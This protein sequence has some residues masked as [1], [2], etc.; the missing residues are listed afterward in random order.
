[1]IVATTRPTEMQR[2]IETADHSAAALSATVGGVI[3]NE[4]A[5]ARVESALSEPFRA[6]P[7]E[8]G[9]RL[10]QAAE[11]VLEDVAFGRNQQGLDVGQPLLA[12]LDPHLAGLG[13]DE[14]TASDVAN[15]CLYLV[16]AHVQKRDIG[17]ARQ[18]VQVCLRLVPDLRADERLHPPSVRDLVSEARASLERGEGGILAVHAAPTDPE[19]CAIRV[20]GRRMGQTPWARV[21]LPPGPYVVQ[22]ECAADRAGRVHPVQVAGD[23]P[24]RV[25]IHVELAQRLTT[26]PALA[27][28]YTSREQLANHLPEDVALIAHTLGATRMLAAVDD[29][30]N[31][32]VRAFAVSDEGPLLVGSA[33]VPEPID[34]TRSREAVAAVLSGRQLDAPVESAVPSDAREEETAHVQAG[35]GGAPNVAS[36]VLGSILALG[37]AAGL[38]VGWYYWTELEAAWATFDTFEN[39]EMTVAYAQAQDDIFMTRWIVLGTGIGGGALLTM[40]LPFLLP[41]EE[42]V[43]WWSFIPAAAGAALAGVGIWQLTEDGEAIGPPQT[44]T[45]EPAWL[46]AHLIAHAVPLLSVPFIYLVRDATRDRSAGAAVHVDDQRAELRV[47]GSF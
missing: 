28:V 24:T 46:G 15:L 39:V 26:R 2:A 40:A 32:A 37:G 30:R 16:R 9:R 33:P 36:L 31:L 23:S 1:M 29:G 43:P 6:A 25:M 10:G 41:H 42:G 11:A 47:W 3:P 5:V 8:I 20:N 22:I 17:A 21:P 38:C 35:G 18:Q 13:R 19:G 4:R 44:L 7:P 34:M 12:E 45:T 14:Q 27:L